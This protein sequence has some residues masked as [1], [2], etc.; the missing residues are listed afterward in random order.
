MN[1]GYSDSEDS[2][3]HRRTRDRHGAKDQVK[4]KSKRRH[5]SSTAE[6][7]SAN[8]DDD[9][10]KEH[11][12]LV[13]KIAQAQEK[14]IK[15]FGFKRSDW[16]EFVQPGGTD[17]DAMLAKWLD[18]V[19]DMSSV[20]ELNSLLTKNALPRNQSSKAQKCQVLWEKVIAEV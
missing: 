3:R 6:D 8:S 15:M 16:P 13:A 9:K 12:S 14:M 4:Y 7:G 1:K 10:K 2:E 19:A 20:K 11:D 18:T 5:R 17:R